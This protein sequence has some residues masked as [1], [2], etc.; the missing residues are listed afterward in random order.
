MLV[1]G[2]VTLTEHEV[3]AE[4]LLLHAHEVTGLPLPQVR[5]KLTFV[6]AVTGEA[7]VFGVWPMLQLP[8]AVPWFVDAIKTVALNGDPAP[9]VFDGVTE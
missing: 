6:P 7:A 8:G 5:F 4:I 2:A 1:D 3:V 9:E